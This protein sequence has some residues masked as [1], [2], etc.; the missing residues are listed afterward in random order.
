MDKKSLLILGFA[1]VAIGLFIIPSTMSMFMGQ[2]RWFT[3]TDAEGQYDMCERCHV[4]EVGEWRANTGAHSAYMDENGED[5]GCFCHQINA[6]AL[7]S[8]GINRT[9]IN[10]F[11]YEIFNGTGQLNRSDKEEWN[12]SWRTTKTPHAALTIDCISCHANASDQLLNPD[13]AHGPFFEQA[14]NSTLNPVGNNNTACMAC[15]TMIG[16]NIT[17]ER[18]EGGLFINANHTTDY[19]WTINVTLNNTRTNQ[20]QYWA[21]NVTRNNS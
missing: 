8:Y 13:E 6:S 11:N 20:S 16:L 9:E 5:P 4:A 14:R 10:N 21:P 7:E 12:A 3:V 17:M 18:I 1:I 19:N 2:H 15:H